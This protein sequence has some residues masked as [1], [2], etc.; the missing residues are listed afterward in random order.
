MIVSPIGYLIVL[1]SSLIYNELIIFNFCG[2]SKE[3]KK[4]VDQRGKMDIQQMNNSVLST[5]NVA[6][7][8]DELSQSF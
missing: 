8:D 1:F 7:S 3:T 6:N 4:F 2:L 5:G